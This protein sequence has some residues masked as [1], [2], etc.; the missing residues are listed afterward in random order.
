MAHLDVTTSAALRTSAPSFGPPMIIATIPTTATTILQVKTWGEII[1]ICQE[2]LRVHSEQLEY[3]SSTE[4]AMDYLVRNHG[5]AVA[6]LVGGGTIP[7]PRSTDAP[8][9]TP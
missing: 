6:E 2:R 3:R 9:V 4:H 8:R 1:E 7:A 5:D